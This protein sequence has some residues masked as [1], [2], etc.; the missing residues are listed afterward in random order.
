MLVS[1]YRVAVTVP[2]QTGSTGLDHCVNHPYTVIN[3]I[4]GIVGGVGE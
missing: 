1:N 2:A 4:N 3:L